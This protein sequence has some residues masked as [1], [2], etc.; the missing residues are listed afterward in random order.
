MWPATAV[1]GILVL[2]DRDLWDLIGALPRY[3]AKRKFFREAQNFLE[4]SDSASKR[5]Q[6]FFSWPR[7]L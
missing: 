6:R 1:S 4:R 3:L 5:G 2:V 7:S